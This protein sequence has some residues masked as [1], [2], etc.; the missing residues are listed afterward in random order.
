[1]G[2]VGTI[3][4]VYDNYWE[5]TAVGTGV[6]INGATGI[7]SASVVNARYRRTSD[8][9]IRGQWVSPGNLQTYT[10]TQRWNGSS[11][12][13]YAAYGWAASNSWGKSNSQVGGFNAA[14]ISGYF[15]TSSQAWKFTNNAWRGGTG[16]S[17]YLYFS[18]L[19]LR[20]QVTDESSSGTSSVTSTPLAPPPSVR[21]AGNQP[22][23]T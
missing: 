23:S 1:M 22:P 3:A 9:T 17:P 20:A 21:Q 7:A 16:Y 13:D 15:R 2:W 6:K 8:N 12:Y 11:W 19:G 4:L 5:Q 10:V 14:G 18:G